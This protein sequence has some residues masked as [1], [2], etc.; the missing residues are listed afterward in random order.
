[1]FPLFAAGVRCRYR[2]HL[3]RICHWYKQHSGTA[4]TFATGV[5]DTSSKFAA[6]VVDTCGAP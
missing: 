4:G 1:M 5:V 3:W 2:G 6:G